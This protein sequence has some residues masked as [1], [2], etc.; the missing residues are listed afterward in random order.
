M[1]KIKGGIVKKLAESNKLLMSEVAIL[2][3]Q[4]NT[5][6]KLI[7]MYEKKLKKNEGNTGE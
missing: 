6:L 2:R 1:Y 5:L 7:R 3:K 4:I